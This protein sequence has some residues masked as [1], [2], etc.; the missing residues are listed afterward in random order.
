MEVLGARGRG[1]ERRRYFLYLFLLKR[2]AYPLLVPPIRPHNNQ[3]LPCDVEG[4][5]P[6]L[7]SRWRPKQ[8]KEIPTIKGMQPQNF[9][10]ALPA[11]GIEPTTF[12]ST[13]QGPPA[14]PS[15]E[16]HRRRFLMLD[17][18][19]GGQLEGHNFHVTYTL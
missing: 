6:T 7:N 10:R 17:Y 19:S 13:C 2:K 12:A 4:A 8:A 18:C 14:G 3:L 16:G 15:H 5:K 11:L 1:K 9:S